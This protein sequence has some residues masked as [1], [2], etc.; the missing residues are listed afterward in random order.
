MYIP[1]DLKMFC[2]FGFLLLVAEVIPLA[3]MS[4]VSRLLAKAVMASSMMTEG[5]W[6]QEFSSDICQRIDAR[7][8]D[9]GHHVNLWLATSSG[10]GMLHLCELQVL[11]LTRCPNKQAG[12][13]FVHLRQC[14]SP[15]SSLCIQAPQT[16]CWKTTFAV[17]I[18]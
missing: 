4:V 8:T 1:Y 11:Q 7:T 10:A 12:A 17:L 5:A 3:K 6:N 14:S 16:C 18:R 15:K 13:R 9:D 2:C